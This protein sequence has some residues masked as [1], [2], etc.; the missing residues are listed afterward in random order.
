MGSIG[1]RADRVHIDGLDIVLSWKGS[2]GKIRLSFR[3]DG[4][5]EGFWESVDKNGKSEKKWLAPDMATFFLTSNRERIA[6]A[7]EASSGVGKKRG[8]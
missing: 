1:P 3:R 4:F 8:A 7:I 2:P 6:K 5:I